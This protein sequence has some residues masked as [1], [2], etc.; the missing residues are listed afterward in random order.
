MERM[1]PE[2][3]GLEKLELEE[4]EGTELERPEAEEEVGFCASKMLYGREFKS[5]LMRFLPTFRGINSARSHAFTSY[6]VSNSTYQQADMKTYADETPVQLTETVT[7]NSRET[8][9]DAQIH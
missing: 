4:L 8:A 3:P 7:R 9:F 6:A 5:L 1:A 2:G